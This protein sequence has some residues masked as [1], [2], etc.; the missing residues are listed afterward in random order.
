[1]SHNHDIKLQELALAVIQTEA[2]AIRRLETEIHSPSFT[3]A[4]HLMLECRG[5]VVVTGCVEVD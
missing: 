2:D 4:C 5:R 3:A 1:M